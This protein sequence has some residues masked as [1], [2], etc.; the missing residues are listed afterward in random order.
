[1][2]LSLLEQG[3]VGMVAWGGL[4]FGVYALR[5]LVWACGLRSVGF[6][7]QGFEPETLLVQDQQVL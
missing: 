4:G 7:D 1:M 5:S 2:L 3:N 6:P